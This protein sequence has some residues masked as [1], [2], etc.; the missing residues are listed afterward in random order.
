MST[1]ET[2]LDVVSA[3]CLVLGAVLSLSAGVGLVRFPDLISRMHAGAKP[4]VLGLLLM[5]LGALLQV[6][7][8]AVP[9]MLLVAAFQVVTVPVATH[10]LARASF[11]SGAADRSRLEVDD[12]SS[13]LRPLARPSGTAGPQGSPVEGSAPDRAGDD[14]SGPVDRGP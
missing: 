14:G 11:R 6:G 7:W 2:V 3:L 5:L 12:L 9:E 8:S 1:L 13:Q 10:L 4:Q